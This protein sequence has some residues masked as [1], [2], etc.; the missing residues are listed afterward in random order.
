M[1]GFVEGIASPVTKAAYKIFARLWS[2]IILGS[3]TWTLSLALQANERKSETDNSKEFQLLWCFTMKR[4]EGK[5]SQPC[6][7]FSFMGDKYLFVYDCKL[8][9][10]L[11]KWKCLS[12]SSFVFVL[13]LDV[14]EIILAI[15]SPYIIC[16]SAFRKPESVGSLF[17]KLFTSSHPSACLWE[18]ESTTNYDKMLRLCLLTEHIS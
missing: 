15:P 4:M 12:K 8:I 5:P 6:P 13:E 9:F 10:Y 18:F 17:R 11:N 3:L 2:P 16:L 14:R 1:L 7:S